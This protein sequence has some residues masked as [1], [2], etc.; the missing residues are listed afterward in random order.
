MQKRTI[1]YIGLFSLLLLSWWITGCDNTSKYARQPSTEP[2]AAKPSATETVRTVAPKPPQQK[3]AAWYIRL[4][5]KNIQTGQ[6][7]NGAKF[8]VLD[9]DDATQMYSLKAFGSIGSSGLDLVFQDETG[10]VSGDQLVYYRQ[11]ENGVRQEW[12]FTVRSGESNVT[13]AL[14]MEGFYA[15]T[16]YVDS[17]DRIRFTETR[18]MD[19]PVLK[20]MKLVDSETGEE[21]PVMR[22]GKPVV[23]I[24]DMNGKQTYHFK[25]VKE[26]EPVQIPLSGN[27]V[28]A[29]KAGLEKC[30]VRQSTANV[31]S[32]VPLNRDKPFDIT[33]PPKA[34]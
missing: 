15:L 24:F 6:R 31:S 10:S 34:K 2:S 20:Q 14:Q 26:T 28:F 21:I 27:R 17:E 5:V 11:S 32:G 12:P 1:H 29:A 33:T 18:T 9:R 22:K 4:K 16:S 7:F 19:D 25:W 30:R 3:S 13:I 23:Y 8:G